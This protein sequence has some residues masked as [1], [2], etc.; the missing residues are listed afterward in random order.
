MKDGEVCLT[1]EDRCFPAISI[2]FHISCGKQGRRGRYLPFGTRASALEATAYWPA[3]DNI[4]T[5][6][7]TDVWYKL[8]SQLGLIEASTCR[9]ERLL[10]PDRGL[11]LLVRMTLELVFSITAVKMGLS[12]SGIPL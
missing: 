6:P 11:D 5:S 4:S 12:S 10:I 1:F 9:A 7:R 8:C 3:T 2:W